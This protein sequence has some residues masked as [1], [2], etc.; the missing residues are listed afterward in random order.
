MVFQWFLSVSPAATSFYSRG[1]SKFFAAGCV[2]QHR[3][4]FSLA[5]RCGQI[6]GWGVDV[7]PTG[8]VRLQYVIGK[9]GEFIIELNTYKLLQAVS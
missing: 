9:K 1:D 8:F 2:H 7:K 3:L 6:W 5:E 4:H